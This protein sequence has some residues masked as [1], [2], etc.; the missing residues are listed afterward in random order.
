MNGTIK[1]LHIISSLKRG[2]RERQLYNLFKAHKKSAIQFKIVLFYKGN[3]LYLQANDNVSDIIILSAKNHIQRLFQI[4]RIFNDEKPDI[5]WSW[6]SIE[7]LYCFFLSITGR[8]KHINGSIRHGVVLFRFD[9]VFRLLI[10][11][12]S[13]YIVSNSKAGL[14]ANFLRR[15]FVF[16]NGTDQKFYNKLSADE[17]QKKRAEIIPNYLS[18]SG[19]IYISIAN[20]IP[21]KDYYTVLKALQNLK[22]QKSFYFFIIGD[23][24]MHKD[25]ERV[26]VAYGL[27][28]RVFL[29]GQIENVQEYLFISDIMIH[30]TRGEGVSNAMLEGMFAGLPIIATNIGGIP[31]T[32]YPGSSLLF[33]YKDE[34]ALFECL[35]KAPEEF[36][37]FDKSSEDY[38]N[39]LAKFSVETMIERYEEIINSV[40]KK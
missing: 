3:D 8:W 1:T 32:V 28:E 25:I 18:N 14:K 23:G 13:R 26:I 22:N 40:I 30:S 7:A 21:Y 12:L 11:H 31:E 9:Q 36:A 10:L 6:G 15:G 33:P 17:I 27:K 34:K 24:P 38:R 29:V 39:H 20:L 35:L 2:G 19:T 37:S 16:Y 4:I 5:V